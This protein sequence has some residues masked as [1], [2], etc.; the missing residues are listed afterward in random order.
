MTHAYNALVQNEFS[1]LTLYQPNSLAVPATSLLPSNLDSS[2]SLGQDFAVV[3]CVL[4]G[5][6]VLVFFELVWQ[7]RCHRL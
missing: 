7:R 6:R 1:G 4:L 3:C 5:L 2:L